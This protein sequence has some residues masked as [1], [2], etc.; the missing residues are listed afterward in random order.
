MPLSGK[1]AY[2][3]ESPLETGRSGQTSYSANFSPGIQINARGGDRPPLVAV[4]YYLTGS[5]SPSKFVR[6]RKRKTV[7]KF[8]TKTNDWYLSQAVAVNIISLHPGGFC[9]DDAFEV[10][11]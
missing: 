5:T 1:P 4:V 3:L 8:S 10:S 11:S 7:L 9:A 6:R 2:V